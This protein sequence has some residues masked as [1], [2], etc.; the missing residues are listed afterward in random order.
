MIAERLKIARLAAKVSQRKL[1]VLMEMP[2][3]TAGSKMNQYE[4][5]VH[6]PDYETVQKMAE[7]LRLPVSYFYCDNEQELQLILKFNELSKTRKEELLEYANL[8]FEDQLNKKS[9]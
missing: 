2:E 3:S 4:N 6:T 9:E 8:L 7:V 5:N 1:G